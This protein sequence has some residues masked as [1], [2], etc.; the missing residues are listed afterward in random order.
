MLDA[1]FF[2]IISIALNAKIHCPIA[3]QIPASHIAK[4][5]HKYDKSIK[6]INKNKLLIL[7]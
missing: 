6:Y 3:T 5:A 2:P 1:G 7:L 4:P